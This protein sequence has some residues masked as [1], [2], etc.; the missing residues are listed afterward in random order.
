MT[1][2]EI[3]KIFD[4]RFCILNKHSYRFKEISP[5]DVK[6]FF[7]NEI[8]PEVCS[9]FAHFENRNRTTSVGEILKEK[10]NITL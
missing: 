4:E 9:E 6:D 1:L 5:C 8:L 10:Y 2:E 3:E 7:L